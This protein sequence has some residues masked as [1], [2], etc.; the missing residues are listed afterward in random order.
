MGAGIQNRIWRD[1]PEALTNRWLWSEGIEHSKDSC[2]TSG[3]L[4]GNVP[5]QVLLRQRE[6]SLWRW[7]KVRAGKGISVIV[8]LG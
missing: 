3:R 1:H 2:Q 5:G 4:A 7:K 8:V 6:R